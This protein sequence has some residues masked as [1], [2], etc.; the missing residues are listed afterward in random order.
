M[1]EHEVHT[2]QKIVTDLLDFAR[3]TSADRQPVSVPKIVNAPS[4][5][6]QRL[7]LSK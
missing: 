7:H 2:A 1:I 4:S 5:A 6:S 3:V